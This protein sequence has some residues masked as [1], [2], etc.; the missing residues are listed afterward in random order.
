MTG[1]DNRKTDVGKLPGET[2]AL[3]KR[4]QE[5]ENAEAERRRLEEALRDSEER[6]AQFMYHLP[7][8]ADIKDPQGRFLFAN[9]GFRYTL[10]MDPESLIGKTSAD[11]LPPEIAKAVM[12]KEDTVLQG[13][14]V[15]EESERPGRAPGEKTWWLNYRFPI[16]RKGKPPLIGGISVDVTELH[17]TKEEIEKTTQK[18]RHA[19]GAIILTLSM[20]AEIR[21]PYTAGHQRRVSDLARSIAQE[22]GIGPDVIHGIRL[23]GMIHDI[24]K[25]SIPS[26]ILTK[27]TR[28]TEIE[29]SLIRIH[30]QAAFDILEKI[31]F[32]WPIAGIIRQHHERLDGSGYPQGLK[33]D[34]ICL[35]ARILAVADVVEAMASHRPYRPGLGQD[36]ALAE[37][38]T[39]RGRLYDAKVVDA[40]LKV[41]AAG[42]RF[43]AN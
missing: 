12:A 41:F 6:F 32:P 21:D 23:A 40:C 16:Q 11:I 13:Q 27:P 29:F 36:K 4:I 15:Q 31:D 18:L 8:R 26:E 30:S 19:L 42:Y 10:G 22:M 5:L 39:N 28:L 37:I 43:P 33:G 24:G 9:E 25:I 2:A 1:K 34:E 7:G 20:V 38:E 35:E 3:R 17:R 14:I